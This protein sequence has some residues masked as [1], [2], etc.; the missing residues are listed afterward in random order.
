MHRR[1]RLKW[2]PAPSSGAACASVAAAVGDIKN[3]DDAI[4]AAQP[5]NEVVQLVKH[6]D[7]GAFVIASIPEYVGVA[8]EIV[9]D[10]GPAGSPISAPRRQP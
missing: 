6:G 5:H 4:V 10:V 2:R 9:K 1:R 7:A 8:A 3:L